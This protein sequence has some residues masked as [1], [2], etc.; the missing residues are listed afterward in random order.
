M[1]NFQ[2]SIRDILELKQET[3]D[4]LKDY[5]GKDE[6]KEEILNIQK[7]TKTLLNASVDKEQYNGIISN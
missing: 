4:E 2:N 3:L 6:I 1:I 5:E 7:Q